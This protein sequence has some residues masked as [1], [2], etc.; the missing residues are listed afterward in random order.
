ME[1]ANND[2]PTLLLVFTLIFNLAPIIILIV[3]LVTKKINVA[4]TFV[5]VG[6]FFLSQVILRIPILSVVQMLI[7]QNLGAEEGAKIFT[8]FA[9]I[10]LV[11]GL[12]AGLF[13]ESARL[14]ATKTLLKNKL[15]LKNA[16][17]FGLGHGLCEVVSLVGMAYLSN[18]V[19]YMIAVGSPE[20]LP[21]LGLGDAESLL[22]IIDS[23]YTL[24]NMLTALW[25]RFSAVALHIGLS[26][27]VFYGAYTKKSLKFYLLAIAIHTLINGALYFVSNETIPIIVYEILFSL[28]SL[29][30]LIIMIKKYKNKKEEIT[31]EEN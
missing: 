3:L 11:G 27:V 12:S 9:Y 5:G 22:K 7:F 25:E 29:A 30:L 15:D 14:L 19:M 26:L 13:E 17:S 20:T 31:L 21:A 1:S 28:A 16:I 18:L 23:S 2:F 24:G 8:S 6:A 10:V 4:S